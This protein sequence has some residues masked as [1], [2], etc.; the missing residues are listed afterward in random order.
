M[1]RTKDE[2]QFNIHQRKTECRKLMVDGLPIIDDDKLR[3]CWKNYFT[4]LAQIRTSPSKLNQ[5]GNDRTDGRWRMEDGRWKM[6][7]GGWE[8]GLMGVGEMGA[9]TQGRGTRDGGRGMGHR[10]GKR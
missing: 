8:V 7:V 9:G 2:Q 5:D 4:K 6:G 10:R 1:F 3:T